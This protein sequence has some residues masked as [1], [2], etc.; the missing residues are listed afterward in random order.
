ME[1]GNLQE[2]GI[3]REWINTVIYFMSGCFAPLHSSGL[4]HNK[5]LEDTSFDGSGRITCRQTLVLKFIGCQPGRI[6]IDGVK[7]LK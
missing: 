6:K 7:I 2:I 4:S 1:G 5:R 3:F